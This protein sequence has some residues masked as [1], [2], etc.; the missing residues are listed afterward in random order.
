MLAVTALALAGCGGGGTDP[1]APT[2]DEK[3]TGSGPVA[4]TTLTIK[5]FKFDPPSITVKPGAKVT[6]KNEDSAPHT[7]TAEGKFDTGEIAG[8]E[9]ATFTAPDAPGSYDY[10]CMFHNYMRGTLVVK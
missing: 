8:N 2:G 3:Q 9:T 7:A 5:D 6:V 4:A 10:V 1:S